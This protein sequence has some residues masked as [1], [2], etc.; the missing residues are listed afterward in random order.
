MTVGLFSV[1]AG[2]GDL[3]EQLH[4]NFR[5]MEE[6]HDGGELVRENME[7]PGDT[8]QSIEQPKEP[9]GDI[10]V[11]LSC[12]L[13][14]WE[15]EFSLCCWYEQRFEGVCVHVCMHMY[16]CV[17]RHVCVLASPSLPCGQSGTNKAPKVCIL[18]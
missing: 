13:S 4:V 8:C 18:H 15:R 12:M 1:L 10:E 3:Q 5:E 11:S 6:E 16:M 7:L 17:Q 9:D 2:D 14:M